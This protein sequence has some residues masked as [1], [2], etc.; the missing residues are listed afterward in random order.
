VYWFVSYSYYGDPLLVQLTANPGTGFGGFVNCLNPPTAH[1]AA[2][3]GALG[4][5][6]DGIAC[7][8][9]TSWPHACC[10]GSEC[11]LVVD[12]GECE[13]LGGWDHPEW[14]SCH[15][16]PCPPVPPFPRVCC[17]NGVCYLVTEEECEAMGG[18]YYPE[19]PDCD[20]IFC[21]PPP[22]PPLEGVCCVGHDCFINT[23]EECETLGGHWFPEMSDCETSPP[24]CGEP[25]PVDPATW[26]AIKAMFR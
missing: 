7:C 18:I 1:P 5:N 19:L 21:P 10:V 6:R 4:I 3:F 23:E 17:V 13:A 9:P 8:P 2:C 26:G 12:S 20:L 25:S 24:P 16:N 11:V 14:L 22:P 15:P